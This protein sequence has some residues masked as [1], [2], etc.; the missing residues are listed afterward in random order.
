MFIFL[1]A[2]Q[3]EEWLHYIIFNSDIEDQAHAG[4]RKQIVAEKG[5]T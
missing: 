3:R 4:C 5:F 2:F 1:K